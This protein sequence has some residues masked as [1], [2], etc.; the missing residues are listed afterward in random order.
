MVSSIAG[1]VA[2][3]RMGAYAAS[4]FA[5]EAIAI[6]L[7]AECAAKGRSGVRVLVVRPGPVDTPFR[8]HS[9]A[10]GVAA[11]VRPRGAKVQ[12][13]EDVA[14]QILRGVDSGRA[15]VETTSFVR[16]AAMLARVAPAVYRHVAARMA[17]R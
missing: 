8:E 3:P 13:P 7:R 6:A 12:T 2:S 11:G 17:G 4:K 9:I 1:V 10:K 15:V 16:G 5:L 14:D